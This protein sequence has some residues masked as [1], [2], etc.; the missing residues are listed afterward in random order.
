MTHPRARPARRPRVHR[1]LGHPGIDRRVLPAYAAGAVD[2]DFVVG[3][4][5]ERLSR[6][7][8][9]AE[10]SHPTHELLWNRRGA[11]LI[12]TGTRVWTVTPT[13][14]LWMPAGVPHSGTAPAGTWYST[15]HVD[16]AAVRPLSAE[17]TAVRVTPLLRALLER[18]DDPGLTPASRALTEAMVLDV[19]E[20]SP[21]ELLVHV[22]D[23]PLLAPI[24][25]AVLEHPSDPRT[26][27]QWS[28]EL[29]VSTRTLTRAFQAGTGLGFARWVGSVRAQRAVTLLVQGESVEDVAEETGYASASAF[30][31]AF[32]RA[33]GLTPSAFRLAADPPGGPETREA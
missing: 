22:P 6:P 4:F 28:Q 14:G 24:V 25:R 5:H 7:T 3:G 27:A 19:L 32:R 15:A 23:A 31:A 10:H 20:P 9:W 29:G 11:S 2:V 21:R 13:L 17:P 8:E 16:V 30:G 1:P 26:L 12:T 33:T 18:L